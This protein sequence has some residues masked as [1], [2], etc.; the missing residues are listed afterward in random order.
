[1]TK[2]EIRTLALSRLQVFPGALVYDV[3]AG[4]GSVAVECALLGGQVYAVEKN[5]RS[6]ELIKENADRFKISL[7]IVSGEAPEIL[8]ELPRP[9]RVFLG[10]SGGNLESILESCHRKL[11]PGGRLALT[12]VT[13]DHGPRTYR[14]LQERG[15]L[16]EAL[17]IQVSALRHRGKALMW[18]GGNPV[19]LISGEKTAT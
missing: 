13:L 14:F 12:A 17:Q 7:E 3:G 10:G 11:L 8:Q 5:P 6:Q 18:E 16:M 15:Y 1:M 2:R 4:S 19:T 9:H